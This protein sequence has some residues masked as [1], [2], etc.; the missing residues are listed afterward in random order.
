MKTMSFAPFTQSPSFPQ[1]RG[2]MPSAE[3]ADYLEWIKEHGFYDT[4]DMPQN[5]DGLQRL[6]ESHQHDVSV[7]ALAQRIQYGDDVGYTEVQYDPD[8]GVELPVD[9][10]YGILDFLADCAL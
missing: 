10:T 1:V 4:S 3:L 5:L 9:D 7:S 2:S 6:L 8:T